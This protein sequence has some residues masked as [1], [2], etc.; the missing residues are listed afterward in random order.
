MLI[1]NI[2][3]GWINLIPLRYDEHF[4]AKVTKRLKKLRIRAKLI[5]LLCLGQS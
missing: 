5:F 1:S 3:S 2:G 4:N